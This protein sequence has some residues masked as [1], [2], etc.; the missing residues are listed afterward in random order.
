MKIE[1]RIHPN[2]SEW[3]SEVESDYYEDNYK[4]ENYP[5]IEKAAEAVKEWD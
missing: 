5:E 2:C 4:E 1:R 3:D